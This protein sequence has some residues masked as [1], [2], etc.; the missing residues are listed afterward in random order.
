[1]GHLFLPFFNVLRY[2]DWMLWSPIII[3]YSKTFLF[4]QNK[5]SVIIIKK[6]RNRCYIILFSALKKSLP[7]TKKMVAYIVESENRGVLGRDIIFHASKEHPTELEVSMTMVSEFE[8][9]DIPF[10]RHH[11]LLLITICSW[12]LTIH[13]RT[14]FSGK[15]K[16]L[17]N[18][19]MF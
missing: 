2:W 9:V 12:V 16:L 17:V 7:Q 6:G 15:K 10:A 11:N 19:D 1:M 5:L 3:F 14:E 8:G 18:K 4:C 13:N